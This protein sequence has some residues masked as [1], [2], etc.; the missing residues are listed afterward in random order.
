MKLQVVCPLVAAILHLGQQLWAATPPAGPTGLKVI[1]GIDTVLA[2]DRVAAW[3]PGVP[4]GIPIYPEGVNV[5][6]APYNAVGNGIADD[7]S[8]ITNAIA[9]C[10]NGKAVFFPAGTYLVSKQIKIENKSIV[11]RGAGASSTRLLLTDTNTTDGAN[12]YFRGYSG[13]KTPLLGGYDEGS[14]KVTLASTAAFNIGDDVKVEQ[15]NDPEVIEGNIP[16]GIVGGAARYQA[17][18]NQVIAK[19]TTSLTLKRPLFCKYKASM[20]PVIQNMYLLARCGI[21]NMYLDQRGKRDTTVLMFQSRHCWASGIESTNANW[22][23][24]GLDT[25]FGCELR[26]SFLHHAKTYG[27]GGYGVGIARSTDCLVE[28]NILYYLRHSV[29]IQNG[30]AGNVIAYNYSHRAFDKAYPNTDYLM[31][32]IEHHGGHPHKNLVEGNVCVKLT[33]DNYWGSSRHNTL[34]RNHVERYSQGL[35]KIVQYSVWAIQIDRAQLS[36]NVLGNIL[37]RP[38]DQG[39]VVS[40]GGGEWKEAY[41]TRVTNTMVFH[42]NFDYVSRTT[43]WD[44]RVP[45][46][47]LPPSLYLTEKPAFFGSLAW[48]AFGP[49]A[50]D[51]TPVH[52]TIP[53]RQRWIARFGNP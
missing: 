42:G 10:A 22:T 48:P 2:E 32:D 7:Y 19:T 4:G 25:S 17:Q 24:V 14:T 46:R 33:L 6:N 41:D 53:A 44:P 18:F 13:N 43:Q 21:E 16:G 8:A 27:Q 20:N 34:F 39:Q 29:V 45:S 38:N 30:A 31:S 3:S 15:D 49:G 12:I 9:K 23:H 28:D 50:T 40:L 1:P 51:T 52:G 26:N 36:H 47:N 35:T 37:C 11:L 5:K